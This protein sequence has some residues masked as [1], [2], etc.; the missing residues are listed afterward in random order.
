MGD[1][2]EKDRHRLMADIGM[3][4]PPPR[5]WRYVAI[6]VM[7]VVLLL[8]VVSVTGCATVK[9]PDPIAAAAGD[10]ARADAD[11][12]RF[13]A[14]GGVTDPT[15][16]AAMWL[17]YILTG[18][19]DVLSDYA[20]YAAAVAQQNTEQR[21][22]AGLLQTPLEIVAGGWAA[23]R[24]ADSG[25]TTSISNETNGDGNTSAGRNVA[26]SHDNDQ[27]LE[28]DGGDGETGEVSQ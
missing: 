20:A 23:A 14:M 28:F 7:I 22:A 12:A 25:G 16:Q 1:Q 13:K 6:G 17:A 27:S 9:T 10:R 3:G 24:V 8:M 19:A 5:W 4:D 11:V 15:A 2:S 21:K 26:D 18:D